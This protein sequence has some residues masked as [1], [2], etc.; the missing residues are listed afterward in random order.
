MAL[1]EKC[2]R[3]LNLLKLVSG[4]SFGA[5]KKNLLNLYK[6]LILSKLDYGAQAY[7]SACDSLLK[8]LD[9]IQNLAL[10]IA[11]GALRSTP[12]NTLEIECGLKPLKLRREE[13]TLKYVRSAPLKSQLPVNDLLDDQSAFT[14]SRSSKIKCYSSTVRQ[15]KTELQLDKKIGKL[16]PPAYRSK[17]NLKLEPPSHELTDILGPKREIKIEEAR[18]KSLTFIREKHAGKTHLYTDGSKNPTTQLTGA[19]FVIMSENKLFLIKLNPTLSVFS[20]ELT[21]IRAALI[22]LKA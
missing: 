1:K 10:R 13:L 14:T 7:N 3:D 6:A 11:T 9:S 12:T 19:A 4:T 20:A 16:A 8:T 22:W 18:K 2:N 17:W 5:D 15:L 21:A